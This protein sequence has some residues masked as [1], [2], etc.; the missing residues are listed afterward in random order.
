MARQPES[1]QGLLFYAFTRDEL[2]DILEGLDV[3]FSGAITYGEGGGMQ[4][5][6][7]IDV[8]ALTDAIMSGLE[9]L[10]A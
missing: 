5:R 7:D 2:A 6:V 9:K 4:I 1:V 10:N 3:E 8:D